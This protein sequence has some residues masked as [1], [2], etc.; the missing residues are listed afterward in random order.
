MPRDTSRNEFERSRAYTQYEYVDVVFNSTAN[1]DTDIR[2]SLKVT[3]P[4][5]IDFE[6]V[7]LNLPEAPNTT[8]IIY[9]DSRAG[10]RPWGQ[11][12]IVLR[13]NIASL[14][15]TLRL[16]VRT[17]YA[18]AEIVDNADTGSPIV[19]G[20]S[21]NDTQ[22]AIITGSAIT[23]YY[24]TKQGT[25]ITADGACL[26]TYDTYSPPYTLEWNGNFSGD[27]FQH[28]G[29][30]TDLST[31]GDR[32][33]ISTYDTTSSAVYART[34]VSGGTETRTLLSTTCYGSDHDYKIEWGTTTVK[35]YIDGSLL[36][37]HTLTITNPLFILISDANLNAS[38]VSATDLSEL[39]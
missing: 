33:I 14:W 21:G 11:G 37:T 34:N 13:S 32:A 39:L 18:T 8:P 29:F 27:A 24:I 2:H 19:G 10:R 15:V 20:G 26:L 31:L 17:D 6:V 36:A 30:S 5:A 35:Y 4:E 28:V 12:Y 3:N 9:R 1:A 23:D 22:V 38:R 7:R 16:T 25:T